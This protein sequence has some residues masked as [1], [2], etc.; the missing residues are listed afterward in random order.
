M[1]N[2]MVTIVTICYNSEKQIKETIESVLH[3]TYTDIEY[4]IIDGESKDNTIEIIK[5]Y[6]DKFKEKGIKYKWISEPDGGIS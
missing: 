3:Q 2:P 5:L 1:N 4:I 6:K